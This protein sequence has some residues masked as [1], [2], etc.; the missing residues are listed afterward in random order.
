M[1][2]RFPEMHSVSLNKTAYSMP[3][4]L[5]RVHSSSHDLQRSPKKKQKTHICE[6]GVAVKIRTR[7]LVNTRPAD[8]PSLSLEAGEHKDKNLPSLSPEAGEHK[9]R[10]SPE[11]V[12]RSW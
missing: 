8:L 9:I 12:T 10:R 11:P 1:V 2:L 7:D 5:I 3:R 4:A 6:P